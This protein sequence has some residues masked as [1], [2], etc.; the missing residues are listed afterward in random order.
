MKRVHLFWIIPLLL[1][2]ILLWIR[3]LSPT[4]L[5]DVTPGIS[6]PELEIYNPNILWVIPNFENNP[7]EKNEKWCEEILSLNKTIGMHG[8]HHT[9][10]EFN[11]EIKKEDLEE[12]MNEFKGC[13]GYSPTMFKPPQLKISPEEEE[14]VLNTGMDLKGMFNQVTHKVYHCND[15][16]IPKNKW[17]KIF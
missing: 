2:F 4:E 8:I 13:F 11:N 5:D 9:Y 10:E 12:G 15:S 16:T 1:I 6:C 17:I 3:L 7:I 14:V